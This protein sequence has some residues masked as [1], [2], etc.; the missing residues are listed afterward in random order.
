MIAVSSA[1]LKFAFS[2]MTFDHKNAKLC[3]DIIKSC[4]V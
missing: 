1:L 3:V 4:L 2:A